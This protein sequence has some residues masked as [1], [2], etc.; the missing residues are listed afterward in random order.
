[1]QMGE[2]PMLNR[3][4]EVSSAEGSKRRGPASAA[5]CWATT[6]CSTGRSIC[7]QKVADG[8]LRLDR[9]IEI[10]VTNTSEKKRILKR[11]GPNLDTIQHLLVAKPERLSTGRQPSRPPTSKSTQPGDGWLIRRNKVVRLVEE[12]N[13]RM[14][15][16]LPMWEQLHE[17][18]QR[19]TSIK[20][21]LRHPEE[22]V[23]LGPATMSSPKSCAT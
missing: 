17:I 19:M 9:T 6:S 14:Q 12:L 16:L 13:L 3:D 8:K 4:S 10:S 20:Q 5:R 21:Q 18:S 23:A 22:L 7:L 11:I 2:I 1:M 15:R